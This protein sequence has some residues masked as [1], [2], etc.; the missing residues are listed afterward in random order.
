[1]RSVRAKAKAQSR[2][3]TNAEDTDISLR[4]APPKATSKENEDSKEEKDTRREELREEDTKV[5]GREEAMGERQDTK[6]QD[7]SQDGMEEVK[8]ELKEDSCQ[9]PSVT[10]TLVEVEGTSLKTAPKLLTR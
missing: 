1:M 10:A 7:T 9:S 2:N 8:Q 3:A 4:T 5:R 6:E